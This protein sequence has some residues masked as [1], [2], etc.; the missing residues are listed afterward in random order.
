MMDFS[1][2]TFLTLGILGVALD[3]KNRKSYVS[4]FIWLAG[5]SVFFFAFSNTDYN[6]QIFIS[7]I[8][9][10]VTLF[11]LV[12]RFLKSRH[13]FIAI[14]G[15]S[16]LLVGSFLFSDFLI[17]YNDVQ[18]ALFNKF[19]HTS[20]VIAFLSFLTIKFTPVLI[21]K[22]HLQETPFKIGISIL[23]PSISIFLGAF[24]SSEL[25]VLLAMVP[26]VFGAFF[27]KETEYSAIAAILLSFFILM[28][29]WFEI[30]NIQMN[31]PDVLLGVTLGAGF[32]IVL[33]S[34]KRTKFL[35]F[36]LVL[37]LTFVISIGIL[38]AGNIFEL[39][40]GVDAFVALILAIGLTLLLFQRRKLAIAIPFILFFLG[41]FF[42]EK[43]ILEEIDEPKIVSVE[44][45][46]E[47]KEASE[48]LIPLDSLYGI[49][50]FD[51]EKSKV[52]FNVLGR[53]VTKGA[54]DKV[55]GKL[56]V[57]K[58]SLE[59]EL[60]LEN[61]TTFSKYRDEELMGE[62]Y[63]HAEKYPKMTYKIS[64]IFSDNRKW[65]G[66]GKFTMLGKTKPLDVSLKFVKN[67][68]DIILKGEGKLNRTE[69]GMSP[70]ATE[71]NE[72]EFTFEVLLNQK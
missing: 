64:S 71:G 51:P 31:H 12:S 8:A 15:L 43:P 66:K 48:I 18:T 47:P 5:L 23:F 38:S 21:R 56:D 65:I 63:F 16:I 10:F 17:S 67:D 50:L 3:L 55:A 13:F 29:S 42:Y 34:I 57:D 54:F 32:G 59:V 26:F 19:V 6:G 58:K 25:G 46:N 27:Q 24:G 30:E 4:H 22:L 72:V 62:S 20:L 52:N 28:T 9:S 61:F 1:I 69:F 49:Y 11:F 41:Y 33:T 40:G 68:D 44:L 36:F 7:I 70:S 37:I 35:V 60:K 53:S 14:I 39:A 2:I 45:K